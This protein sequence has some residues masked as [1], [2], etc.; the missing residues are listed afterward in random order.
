MGLRL[1]VFVLYI[2]VLGA[3][4]S[5]IPKCVMLLV[6]GRPV[7]LYGAAY[8]VA[9]WFVGRRAVRVLRGEI[10]KPWLDLLLAILAD[11]LLAVIVSGDLS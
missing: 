8:A 6:H 5:L 4:A 10:P 2:P 1:I 7:G 3:V 9:L 11:C